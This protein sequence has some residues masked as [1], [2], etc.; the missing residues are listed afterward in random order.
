M[1][2][3]L[4]NYYS[5]GNVNTLGSADTTAALIGLLSFAVIIRFI[6]ALA[7]HD[8]LQQSTSKYILLVV[9]NICSIGMIILLATMYVT[10]RHDQSLLASTNDDR[11]WAVI[12]IILHASHV[13]LSVV[14]YKQLLQQPSANNTRTFHL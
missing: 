12:L 4:T 6:M 1:Y 5:G 8:A 11:L 14:I 10:T 13:C 3:A 7:V 9:T 2:N